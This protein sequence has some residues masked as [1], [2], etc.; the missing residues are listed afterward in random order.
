MSNVNT[1][2]TITHILRVAFYSFINSDLFFLFSLC[3]QLFAVSFAWAY[4]ETP[5]YHH[6]DPVTSEIL[7]CDQ[8]PPGTAVE[9][10]CTADKHTVCTPCPE[11]RFAEQWHWGD[12]C[13]HCTSVCKE[14][15]IVSR[16]CNSTHDQVC[17]CESGYYLVVEFCFQH[18]ACRPGFGVSV[19]GKYTCT[20]MC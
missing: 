11:K 1:K 2:H 9:R 10:H 8:C 16:Q 7:L 20:T 13:Q 12:S 5:K 15:Q 18:T 19:Q 3:S 17:E 4:H 14:G 6:Q